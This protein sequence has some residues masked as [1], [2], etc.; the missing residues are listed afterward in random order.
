MT[1]FGKIGIGITTTSHRPKHREYWQEIILFSDLLKDYKFHFADDIDGISN[2]KNDCLKNLSDCDYIF[3][4]DDDTFP[5][6][7]GWSE[8]FIE[9]SQNTGVQH[10]QYLHNYQHIRK[11]TEINNIGIYNNSAGCMLFLTKE[12]LDKVGAFNTEFGRYGYEH[13]EYS[14]RVMM[15]GLNPHRDMCPIGAEKYI[16]SMDLDGYK[17]FDFIHYPTLTP[18]EMEDALRISESLWMKGELPTIYR[19]L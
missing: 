16:Y 8:F 12:V 1:L 2:A 7:E 9:A 4:F 5:I 11:V 15:A 19:P 3:L 18:T 13:A 14:H 6:Q 17:D 10:F